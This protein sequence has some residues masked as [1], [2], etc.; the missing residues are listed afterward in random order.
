M[1][2]ACCLLPTRIQE[3]LQSPNPLIQIPEHRKQTGMFA[4][5]P[6]QTQQIARRE[7]LVILYVAL[8]VSREPVAMTV[9]SAM[10]RKVHQES[11]SQNNP[12]SSHN[13]PRVN[14]KISQGRPGD[15]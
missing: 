14:D 1:G 12:V 2:C 5:S 7:I 3:S 15:Q 10:S 4:A 11:N 6:Q 9:G 8:P 13:T